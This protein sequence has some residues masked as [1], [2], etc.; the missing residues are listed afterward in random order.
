MRSGIEKRQPA[1][2]KAARLLKVLDPQFPSSVEPPN[3]KF[4]PTGSG[5]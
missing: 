1:G 4:A 2:S 5:V 3:L